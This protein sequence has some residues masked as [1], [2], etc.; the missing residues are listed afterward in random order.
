MGPFLIPTGAALIRE[1]AHGTAE[2]CLGMPV[3]PFEI[4]GSKGWTIASVLA[5]AIHGPFAPGA[6]GAIL[7]AL[8][9]GYD[10]AA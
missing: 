8:P 1:R 10:P 5:A 6:R 7:R 9:T 2:H 3:T 4:V